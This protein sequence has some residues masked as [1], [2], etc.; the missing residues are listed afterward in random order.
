MK[1]KKK[2]VTDKKAI[3]LFYELKKVC[4]QIQHI[5]LFVINNYHKK[6]MRKSVD[7]LFLSLKSSRIL[8]SPRI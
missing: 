3:K 4:L 1:T 7:N 6:Y 5:N 2:I 8:K